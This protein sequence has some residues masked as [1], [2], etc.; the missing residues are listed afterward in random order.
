METKSLRF[1]S[2]D[3]TEYVFR[4][5]E[6]IV[7]STPSGLAH[8]PVVGIFQDE[9]SAQHP[10]AAEIAAK[11]LD[12][13]GVLHPTARLMVMANDPALGTFHAVFADRLGMFEAYPNVPKNAAGFG[14]ATKIIDSEELLR[15]LNADAAQHVDAR[16]YLAARLT[17]FLMNDNDRHP[18]N[19]KWA[20]LGSG[21]KTQWEPI[22]RDRDHAF[23]SYDGVL[24]QFAVLAKAS[25]VSFGA[26]P[27]VAGLTQTSA[28]DARLLAGLEKPVWDSVARALQGRITDAVIHAA[29]F[30]M[31]IEYQASAPEL[32]AV[33]KE[34]RAALPNAANEYYRRLAARV[35][36]HGT[37]STDR[38]VITRVADAVVDVRLES[39][40]KAFFSR[41]FDARETS[42]ILV[43][44]HGG[45][46]TAVVSGRVQRSIPVRVI[47]GNGNNTLVD[48]ST[49]ADNE[50]A[51][52][53]YDSG[54]VA[55]VSY[56]P[57][58]L[59]ERRPWEKTN[60][61]MTPPG[62]DFGGSYAPVVGIGSDRSMGVTP[63]I[64]VIRY[65]YGFTQRP[66]ASMVKLEAEYAN[67]TRGMRVGISGDKRLE[68]SPLHFTGVARMS[69]LEVVNFH[70]FGNAT[71]DSGLTSGY[72]AVQQRQWLANA[73]IGLALGPR[74]DI[75]L[76][77]VLQQSVTDSAPNTY[78]SASRPYGVGT[79]RQAGMQLGARY[80][81][82][83][84]PSDEVPSDQRILV[85]LKGRYVPAALDVRS[86]FEEA[87]VAIG[88]S[89]S[90]PFASIL[91]VHMGGK[92]LYGDFP[93]SEAA[94]IGSN[95][96]VR[97]M[98]TQRYAGDASLYGTSELRIPV[99]QLKLLVPLRVGIVGVAEAGRVYDHGTS[100]GGWHPRTGEGIWFGHRDVSPVLTFLRTTEPGQSGVQVRLGLGF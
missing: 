41:R 89:L 20:R 22:A 21:S 44:L 34:R 3:G 46:D 2:A 8:T 66:Y 83:D 97:S 51:T 96:T 55:G 12:A 30:A 75:S 98:D 99:A 54:A 14:G 100:P 70:G 93:F 11:I 19:W 57:D 84:A 37:D 1:E 73:A 7:E 27:D 49:V 26:A 82:R 25:L 88:S 15:L 4:S 67:K 78:L 76:G 33:L 32:E 13:S 45:D 16:M 52:R 81:W 86:P 31:P 72:F 64:G 71:P 40:G 36:I 87:A 68:S 80:E 91:V 28:F 38:A 10:A 18:G 9:I 17:D 62:R 47:G 95:G 50:Q 43:Y 5:S 23:I 6:K 69:D 58:T 90:L 63:H 92:K 42:E 29:A 74:I 39:R 79:F 77:P 56:G 85:E 35:E 48:T 59:F 61:H 60:G 94:S 65:D 24:L 53:F